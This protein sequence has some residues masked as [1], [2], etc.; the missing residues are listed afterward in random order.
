M[1]NAGLV[2]AGL[3]AAA[4]VATWLVERIL[5][6]SVFTAAVIVTI[7]VT[8]TFFGSLIPTAVIGGFT[9]L[10]QDVLFALVAGAGV[11]RLLRLESI[12]PMQRA[13]IALFAL[14]ALSAL[15]GIGPNGLDSTFRESRN[16]L[17][18]IGGILYFST[19]DPTPEV[20][21]QLGRLW[22][23]A[24]AAFAAIVVFR[25][26]ALLVGAPPSGIFTRSREAGGIRVIDNQNTLVVAQALFILVP[27]W[28]RE[29]VTRHQRWLIAVLL[30]VVVFLQ[31]RTIWI[32]VLT[33]GALAVA[34]NP[35]FGRRA[36]A[37][38]VSAA[39]A[40]AVVTAALSTSGES[41]LPQA[42]TDTGTFVWRF[43]GWKGLLEQEPGREEEYLIGRP[44][45]SGYARELETSGNVVDTSPHN[46]YVETYLRL[47]LV[48]LAVFPLMYAPTLRQLA[49][50]RDEDADL[51]LTRETLLLIVAMQVVFMIA[52]PPDLDQGIII[53]VASAIA[54]GESA[55]VAAGHRARR[56]TTG[57]PGHA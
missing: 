5:R 23:I 47:G 50:R 27:L 6:D 43:E 49:R 9:V 52:W 18:F 7:S 38:L 21:R 46:F 2:A 19:V 45:G 37:A 39:A 56:W 36:A 48:G 34:R 29:T 44:L 16:F 24:G 3:V 51:L 53:G 8:S 30:I 13:V 17:Y 42:P 54:F 12:N 10:P 25:W 11:L 1:L 20:R 33:A 55:T 22:L 15:R 41:P 31:H 14:V 40:V 57:E 4:L 28:I 35:T 26:G 32:V